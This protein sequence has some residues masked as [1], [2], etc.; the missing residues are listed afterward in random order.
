MQRIQE[1]SKIPVLTTPESPGQAEQ[2]ILISSLGL[3]NK[4]MF[5]NNRVD[6]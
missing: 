4:R 6:D 5:E 1:A 2:L 3:C